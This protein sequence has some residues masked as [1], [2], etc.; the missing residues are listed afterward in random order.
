M[1]NSIEKE[2]LKDVFNNP[3]DTFYENVLSDF[4]DEQGVEHDFRK[5]LHNDKITKLKPYQ[6]KCL[7]IWIKHWIN[8]GLCTKP[9]DKDKAEQY[10]FDFYKELDLEKFKS[11]VWFDNPIDM[12]SD[13][14]IHVR[15]YGWNQVWGQVWNQACDHSIINNQISNQTWNHIW[16]QIWNLISGQ[17][18]NQVNDRVWNQALNK[19]RNQIRNQMWNR[20]WNV[21]HDIHWL[22]YYSY[23]MQV[24]RVRLSKVLIPYILLVQ[25][26]NWWFP[27]EE[28]IF[29]VKKPKEYIVKNNEL[30]KLV[31][32]DNYTIT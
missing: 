24:L 18:L 30:V 15:N 4:L 13:L 22:A 20:A 27:T 19:A 28:T 25:E 21:Q 1:I 17:V 8:I 16:H 26:I 2:I 9:T 23:C 3:G 14:R 11:I 32:Q 7:D 5:P 12:L 31:Y 10:F 6:N 29:V